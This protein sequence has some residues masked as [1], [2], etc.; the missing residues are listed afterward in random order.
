M[1][2]PKTPTG[3]RILNLAAKQRKEERKTLKN[4]PVQFKLEE[5]L[6]RTQAEIQENLLRAEGEVSLKQADAQNRGALTK[7][8]PY[9][10]AAGLVLVGI[11]M[12]KKRNRK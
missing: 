9:L 8:I 12:L 10:L 1:S 5:R 11:V 6:A 7:A 4:L 2:K 3:R